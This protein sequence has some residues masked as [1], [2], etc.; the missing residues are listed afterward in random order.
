[1]ALMGI[2]GK[3]HKHSPDV[4][5]ISRRRGLIIKEL[6]YRDYR[7]FTSTLAILH[8]SWLRRVSSILFWRVLWFPQTLESL[9]NRAIQWVHAIKINGCSRGFSF[10][11]FDIF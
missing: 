11:T 6:F 10:N 7:S 2:A 5:T 9:W 4:E 3:H 8:F 1:M